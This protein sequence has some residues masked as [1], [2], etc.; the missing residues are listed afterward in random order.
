MDGHPSDVFPR[1][2]DLARVG[3][4]EPGHHAEHRALAAARWPQEGEEL[5]RR[6][7]EGHLVHG[8]DGAE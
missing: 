2:H 5:A 6:G 1:Q 3:L 7:V 4:H 8:D